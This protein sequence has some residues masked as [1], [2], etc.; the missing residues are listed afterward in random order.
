MLA[1][2]AW[3]WDLPAVWLVFQISHHW[4]Q[5]ALPRSGKMPAE[6]QLCLGERKACRPSSAS[7]CWAVSSL[8]L[9][10]YPVCGAL[11]RAFSLWDLKETGFW[12]CPSPLVPMIFPCLL[13]HIRVEDSE[14]SE[15]SYFLWISVFITTNSKKLLWWVEWYTDL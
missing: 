6:P 1:N 15:V 5:L 3:V 14:D 8:A 2:Y 13:D 7:P 10:K 11:I 9:Y 12:C 4:R